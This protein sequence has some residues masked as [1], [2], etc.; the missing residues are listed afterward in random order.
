MKRSVRRFST[1]IK[2]L[3]KKNTFKQVSKSKKFSKLLVNRRTLEKIDKGILY[4]YPGWR[5]IHEAW[6]DEKVSHFCNAVNKRELQ[7]KLLV[8]LEAEK[9]EVLLPEDEE[10]WYHLIEDKNA[11]G[12][13]KVITTEDWPEHE[14]PFEQI[15]HPPMFDDWDEFFGRELERDMKEDL[16]WHTRHDED[17]IGLNCINSFL[18]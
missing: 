9:N 11:P 17:Q 15:E 7:H 14:E 2:K 18:D 1:E 12:G 16:Y 5:K 6:V 10:E 3:K 4:E 13:Y 8:E